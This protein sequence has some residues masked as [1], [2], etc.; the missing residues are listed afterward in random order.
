[1]VSTKKKPDEEEGEE[2]GDQALVSGKKKKDTT[3][4]KTLEEMESKKLKNREKNIIRDIDRQ[5]DVYLNIEKI[6][7]DDKTIH[8]PSDVSLISY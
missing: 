1:M 7:V 3:A 5:E 4:A 6:K 8:E 2:E